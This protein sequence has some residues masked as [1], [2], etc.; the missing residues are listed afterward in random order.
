MLLSGT[1]LAQNY[2]GS[3]SPSFVPHTLQEALASAYLTNPTLREERARLRATDERVPAALAGWRPTIQG[4][5]QLT[6]YDGHTSYGPQGLLTGSSSAYNTPGYVGG[7]TVTQPLYQG[8][9]TVASTHAATNQVMAERA[10]LISTEQEVFMNVVSA[11]VDVIKDEQLLQLATNNQRVLE[12]QLHAT[13]ERFHIGEITRTDVAQAEAAYASSVAERQQAEGTLQSAQAV[14]L[15]VVGIAAPP[16]LLPPQP[17]DLPV[18]NEQAALQIAAENNPDI[19]S[20]LFAEAMQKD[21]VS[22]QMAAIMPKVSAQLLY[23]H[24][25]NQGY[26]NS[27]LDNKAG[28]I[29]FQVPIYQGGS[30]YSSVRSARQE[31]LAAHREIDVQ[32][33]SALQKASSSWQQMT[34]LQSAIKADRVAISANILALSGVERQ[35]LLGTTSTLAVLQQQ[36][37]LLVAQQTLVQHLSNL[38]TS[39]YSVASAIGRLTAADLKIG[40][41]LYDEKAYYNAVKNRLWGISD[42]AQNQPG[43]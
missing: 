43:R 3:G 9:K 6:H 32:R 16:N 17:L 21:N 7:V 30:E 14:Y 23:Q 33:R 10:R 12:Q 24:S 37:T 19:I 36:Q 2:D 31:V 4:T 15:Q 1:A 13:E 26:G 11:Y 20:S 22:V 38:V 34:S 42:Y 29:A 27:T 28:V 35:A 39:S 5:A 41:P 40:V 25:R 18:K 8:G